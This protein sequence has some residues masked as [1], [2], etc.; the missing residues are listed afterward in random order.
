MLTGTN[1]ATT[2]VRRP[3]TTC[4][5]SIEAESGQLLDGLKELVH[6]GNVR[7]V[8]VQHEGSSRIVLGR[9]PEETH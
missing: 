7:R 2:A 5:E 3:N 6:Q 9:S 4:W 1:Y 8:V